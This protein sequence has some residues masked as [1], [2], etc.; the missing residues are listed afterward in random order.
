V[1]GNYDAISAQRLNTLHPKLRESAFRVYNRAKSEGIPIYIVWGT[2]TLAEQAILFR[3]GR[4]IPGRIV[5]TRRATYSAHNYGLAFDFC[6]HMNKVLLDWNDVYERP[7][8]RRKWLRVVKMYEEEG[9]ESGWRWP[10]FEPGHIQNLMGHTILE[11]VAKYEQ[12]K[13]RDN[14]IEAV[15]EPIEDQGIYL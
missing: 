5:T 2:R 13:N 6:L 14:G 12:T 8:W 7:Y 9:W 11:L 4:S 1:T 15:R 10:S 3:F